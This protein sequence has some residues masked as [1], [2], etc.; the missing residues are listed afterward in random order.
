MFRRIFDSPEVLRGLP[1]QELRPLLGQPGAGWLRFDDRLRLASNRE[2]VCYA[3]M[4]ILMTRQ[5]RTTGLVLVN[6]AAVAGDSSA[7]YFLAMLRYHLNPADH[8]SLALILGISSGPSLRDGWW[9]NRR[10]PVQRY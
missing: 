4:E 6:Q 3:G 8:E 2:V 7:T 5:D 10:L 9:E 1:L